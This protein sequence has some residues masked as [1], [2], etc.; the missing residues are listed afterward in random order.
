MAFRPLR[1]ELIDIGGRRLRLVRA[2]SKSSR[3]TILCEHGAFGCGTDWAAVQSRLAAK[4]LYSLAY[5]RAGLG[6]SD[7]G[8]SPR[9]GHAILADLERLLDSIDEP[10]PF[11]LVGHSMAG[12]F[13]RLFAGRHPEKVVGLALV[14]AATAETVEAPVSSRVLRGYA[15]ATAAWAWGAGL[16]AAV[17]ASLVFGDRIGLIGD[18]STE[19]RRIFARAGHHRASAEEVGN[20]PLN[21]RQAREAGAYDPEWPVAVVTAAPNARAP[22]FKAMQMAPAKASRAGYVE[23]VAGSSH[24]T[25]LGEA[26][27]DAVVRGVEH[28]LTAAGR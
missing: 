20:W 25:L 26:Y 17:P 22:S 19:K 7:P 12:I 28:V 27:A 24:A 4:G 23:H 16:G 10:G 18:A 2:G 9:D 21:S 3:P 11:V 5:D 8:P 13:L 1:G 15:R 6:Y 14:D